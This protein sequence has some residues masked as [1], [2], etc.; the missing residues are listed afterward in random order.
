MTLTMRLARIPAFLGVILLISDAV[1]QPPA[2]PAVAMPRLLYV[3]PN[4]AKAGTTVDMIV[5]GS[6]IEEPQGLYF[7]FPGFKA[8]VDNTEPPPDPKQPAKK[9][10]QPAGPVLSTKFKVTVPA[11]APPGLH[12][13][14]LM[15]A[16]GVSNPRVFVV[17]D[18]PEVQ[19]KEPNN[20]VEQAQKVELNSTINGI[21][22]PP[23][24]VDYYSFA[25]KKGQRV[26]A[27]CLAGS[28]ESKL[29]PVVE[30]YEAPKSKDESGKKLASNRDYNGT[31][32]LVDAILPADGDY[33]VR[34]FQFTHLAGGPD[35]YYRLTITTAPWIDAV[36][37]PF[38]EPGKQAQLTVYGRNLPNGQPDPTA[39]LNGSVLEKAT[40]TVS[41]PSE[42]AVIQRLTYS[43]Q[44]NPA[45]SMLDGFEYRLK[46]A[47]GTSNPYLLM[48]ARNPLITDNSTNLTRDKAQEVPVPS[49]VTGKLDKTHTQAWYAF[50]AKKGETYSIELLGE[51]IG[52]PIDFALVL[53]NPDPKL[54]P[55]IELDDVLPTDAEFLSL[56]QFYTRTS[57][58]ARYQFKPATDGKYL[59]LVKSQEA[60]HRSGPRQLYRLRI[61]PE[62]PDFRLV[63]MP[64]S[65]TLPEGAVLRQ[66]GNADYTVFVWRRDGFNQDIALSADGLPPGVTCK[67]QLIGPGVKQ[68][69]LVLGATA[70]AAPWTG[71]I[72]VKGTATVN[73]QPLERE[74]RA[75]TITWAG[76]PQQ[77]NLAT[78]SRLDRS[79]VLAV[80]GK[81]PF[82]LTPTTETFTAKPGDKVTV[83]V[84]I[85]RLDPE[86]KGPINVV[87]TGLPTG[88]TFNNNNAP[89]AVP[90]DTGSLVLTLTPMVAPGNY[91]IVFRGTGQVPF[92]KDPMAKTKPNAAFTLPSAPITVTVMPK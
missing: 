45:S 78:M 32:A 88:M 35:Y 23:I 29:H 6:D 43:G 81:A 26:V 30:I 41:V 64:P 92:S 7:S 28:I 63:V 68:A 22:N 8:E 44:I 90:G 57:D 10:G 46:N 47:A 16:W 51:R 70:D 66:G 77:P 85:E 74:A 42:P 14:R 9:K 82:V 62:Q 18:L 54:P 71:D 76:N 53:Y 39:V 37:P 91:T 69:A 17:G 52:A 5:T 11:D 50:D 36:F 38:V 55:M 84:K 31:D 20:D 2:G 87:A 27:S 79:V 67:P 19:E 33:L 61:S 49:E 3:S 83:P 13:V 1:G 73:G 12:D 24:D 40:V 89:M 4:G 59:V 86:F 58:P 72:K 65:A 25:G 60:T 34:V 21:I 75:A 56:N 80:R 15:N 48:F